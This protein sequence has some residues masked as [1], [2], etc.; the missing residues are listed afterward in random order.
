MSVSAERTN[1]VLVVVTINRP[2]AGD[3]VNPAVEKGLVDEMGGAAT[4]RAT[5]SRAP[6][7]GKVPRHSPKIA[8]QPGPASSS[9][10]FW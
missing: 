8:P 7:H 4:K 2:E 3:S 1:G 10:R 6:M 5:G 9:I